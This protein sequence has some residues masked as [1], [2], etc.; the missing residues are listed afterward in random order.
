MSIAHSIKYN[1][2]SFFCFWTRAFKT[3][4]IYTQAEKSQHRKCIAT[5]NDFTGCKNQHYGLTYKK[6]VYGIKHVNWFNWNHKMK[7]I[8]IFISFFFRL[9][10][11]RRGYTDWHKSWEAIQELLTTK[12][13]GKKI[14]IEY[15]KNHFQGNFRTKSALNLQYVITKL[16]TLLRF[17]IN[18]GKFMPFCS[19]EKFVIYCE[20]REK[21][22]FL[23]RKIQGNLSW[24]KFHLN[25][26]KNLLRKWNQLQYTSNA[27]VWISHWM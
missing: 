20:K 1:S 24:I 23:S 22:H 5:I 26:F 9:L 19:T 27:Q 25:K 18:Y 7:W 14:E 3:K 16:A 17:P 11:N 2:Q 12:C 10:V 4:T 6:L 15:K 8:Q 21:I 13:L